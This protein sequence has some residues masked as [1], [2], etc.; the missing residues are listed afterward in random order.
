MFYIIFKLAVTHIHCF[1]TKLV[2]LIALFLSDHRFKR[3]SFKTHLKIY[4]ILKASLYKD[5]L[6]FH[7]SC[8]ELDGDTD[9]QILF[10]IYTDIIIE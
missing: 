6:Y 3:L 5:W 9:Q 2:W 8:R 10:G 1:K 4:A 7:G